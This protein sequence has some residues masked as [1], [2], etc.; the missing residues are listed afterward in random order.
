MK[1]APA[2]TLSPYEQALNRLNDLPLKLDKVF[3]AAL[4]DL[5]RQR[6]EALAKAAIP[7]DAQIEELKGKL[8]KA[9]FLFD[10]ALSDALLD[11]RAYQLRGTDPSFFDQVEAF[12]KE[13]V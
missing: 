7:A 5:R 4:E 1:A 8:Y 10:L 13:P 3:R 2:V 9:R 6:N 11:A 12:L